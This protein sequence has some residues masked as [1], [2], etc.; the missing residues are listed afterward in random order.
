M[1]K[2]AMKDVSAAVSATGLFNR[3][4]YVNQYS[5]VAKI[6]MEPFNHFCQYGI[7]EDRSPG[8]DFNP[9]LY[10]MENPHLKN[11]DRPTLLIAIEQNNYQNQRSDLLDRRNLVESS[12]VFEP[13]WYCQNNPDVFE[14]GMDA[15]NHFCTFGL[16]EDRPPGPK[17]YPA[18][19]RIE[20]P[21]LDL[22]RR[23]SLLIAIERDD[24]QDH[25]NNML[26]RQEFIK[27]SNLFDPAWYLHNN[28]DVVGAGIDALDHFCALGIYENRL[29]NSAIGWP[30]KYCEQLEYYEFASRLARTKLFDSHWYLKR[31]PDIR[32][33]QID[34]W[35]HF[36]QCGRYEERQPG[37][38]FLPAEYAAA[39]MEVDNSGL[40]SIEYYVKFGQERGHNPI[41]VEV[42]EKWHKRYDEIT[43]TD[44]AD[45]KD[46][47][48]RAPPPKCILIVDSVN[49]S[50]S[51]LA[52]L[53][54]SAYNQLH[55]FCFIG[56]LEFSGGMP[57]PPSQINSAIKPTLIR[58]EHLEVVME[59]LI[60]ETKASVVVFAEG[61][62][63]FRPFFSFL[64]STAFDEP[65][66]K[67][68]YTDHD[69]LIGEKRSAPAFKPEYSKLLLRQTNYIGDV[70]AISSDLSK[71]VA[72]EINKNNGEGISAAT[73]LI[74]LENGSRLNTRRIPF[75]SYHKTCLPLHTPQENATWKAIETFI[76]DDSSL[77]SVEIIIPTKDNFEI[78]YA[79]LESIFCHTAYPA[80]KTIITVIDNQSTQAEAI[81]YIDD[82]GRDGKITVIRDDD[83][84]NY[85]RLNNLAG[86]KSTADILIFLNNDT[87]VNDPSWIHKL[88]SQAKILDV[89]AVGCKLYYPDN[90]IQHAGVV[91]GVHGLAGHRH[92]GMLETELKDPDYSREM[93]AV[94]GAC[95]AVR[96]E[97]FKKCG[98][99]D[100]ALEVAFNDVSLCISFYNQG[101][102]NIYISSPLI[103][104]HESKTRG[105]DDN[106]VKIDRNLREATYLI[107][108]SKD[109]FLN[110]PSYNPNLSLCNLDQPSFPPRINRPWRSEK[111]RHKILLLSSAHKIGY[112]VPVV[113][114]QQARSLILA[115]YD[116]IVGGPISS[117]DVEY[118]SSGRVSIKDEIEAADF[119]VRNKIS[120]IISHTPPFFSVAEH[121]GTGI[122][123]Y[124]LDY[125]EPSPD[126]FA[127]YHARKDV[128]RKKRKASAYNDRVFTISKSIYNQQLSLEAIVSRIG[129]SHLGTWNENWNLIRAEKR[130]D[131]LYN[132]RFVILNVCRFHEQERKYKGIDRFIEIKNEFVK[133]FPHHARKSIFVLAGK[134]NEHDREHVE[135][136]GVKVIANPTD[137]DLLEL[138]AQADL[139]MNFSRWEGYNLGIGQALAMGLPVI[140]SD[141]EAHR[142]FPIRVVAEVL[143]ACIAL[144]EAIDRWQ[145]KCL[146][147]M[148][149]VD[150]WSSFNDIFLSYV[151]ND[152]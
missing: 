31:Y 86:Y 42:Y 15:L 64:I 34:P 19:Y 53:L 150:P 73:R 22:D 104:H 16:Y 60:R 140:A 37:P 88:V 108:K 26:R 58:R 97:V 35:V 129:S 78:L 71:F 12:G 120:L 54:E 43:S 9:A 10:R 105:Y 51:D 151:E 115:G 52:A 65:Q 117:E 36:I 55:A 39:Y 38:G 82:L 130:S 84:F 66:I 63:T 145:E 40:S 138:Y 1:R 69:V 96:T 131:N 47:I 45:I 134:G 75:I 144:A 136:S 11:D 30:K 33:S 32:N 44:I 83:S 149:I 133:L 27:D 2:N 122:K 89:G 80:D 114:K 106:D 77:P 123:T 41:G 74:T 25:H 99:F 100:E 102:R 146:D 49:A 87:T 135:N 92:V 137:A 20:N 132:G 118:E 113:V 5:D 8:P 143:P 4:W 61:A 148:A 13:V 116:V 127:D 110:D 101:L 94:T 119:A 112:G 95:L 98:G 139:Y 121:V 70:L 125:G 90:T 141:I 147:R 3:D 28:P 109:I 17:F 23:P 21:H 152:I 6:G 56:V 29:G 62:N 85:S 107:K 14:A 81:N 46:S 93:T 67:I 48:T 103:Y 128:N 24:L 50:S 124:M 142:E 79:C 7:Y 59:N 76:D 72:A 68:A 57:L 91:L 18:V 111:S 126:W